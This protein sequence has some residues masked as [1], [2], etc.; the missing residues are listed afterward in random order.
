M[1]YILLLL[2]ALPASTPYAGPTTP[3][4]PGEVSYVKK[5]PEAVFKD[6]G[7]EQSYFIADADT[8][9]RFEVTGPAV[10]NI[11]VRGIVDADAKGKA[12]FAVTITRDSAF[13]SANKAEMI[14]EPNKKGVA[15]EVPGRA[16]AWVTQE[17]TFQ[18]AVPEGEHEYTVAP[19]DGKA[20]GVLARVTKATAKDPVLAAAPE[21]AIVPPLLPLTPK[22]G[23]A[24][25]VITARRE[26]GDA[27]A[28]EKA[29]PAPA[30]KKRA[31]KYFSSALKIDTLFPTNRVSSTVAVTVDLRYI[32]PVH[33]NRISLGVETGWYS[34]YGSGKGIDPGIGVYDYTYYM[35]NIPIFIGPAYELPIPGLDKTPFNVFVSGGFAMVVSRASGFMFGG[36]TYTSGTALGW[37]GGAGAEF[38]IWIGRILCE[39]RYQSVRTD[40]GL[41]QNMDA[42]DLGGTHLYAGYRFVL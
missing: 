42:G 31:Q 27:A 40:Y 9:L 30:E 5:P 32:L 12:A 20:P 15:V 1:V 10:L 33:E 17:R 7:R 19:P 18:I 3:A 28:V 26:G 13:V 21:V 34:M 36:N 35:N 23:T 2:S 6:K 14:P 39:V 41:P 11:G 8:P 16:G 4:E 24:D 38:D 37:Y 25:R 22:A 29:A